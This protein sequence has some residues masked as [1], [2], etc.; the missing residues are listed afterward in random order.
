MRIAYFSPFNPLKSGISDFSEELVP[1]LSKYVEIDLF[2]DGY[3]PSNSFIKENLNIYDMSEFEDEAV[4]SKY[5]EYIYH[6]GNNEKCHE[7]IVSYALRYPGI[8]ELHDI[9]L[10]H[11]LAATTIVGNNV[12]GYKK[13]MEYCHGKKGIEAVRRFLNGETP[14]PWETDSLKYTVCKR[15]ID[16]SKAVIVHSDFAKQMIKGMNN[17][18]IVEKIYLHTPDIEESFE[19]NKIRCREDLKIDKNVIMMASFGFATKPKRIIEIMHA[20]KKLKERGINFLYYIVGQADDE[21]QLEKLKNDLG[22]KDNVLV[23]GFVELE[24]MKKLMGA[25]DICFNLRNPTQGE[26]SAS[27]HR[28]I[29]MGKAVFVSNIG[30]FMEYPDDVVVKVSTKEDEIDDI[31]NKLYNLLCTTESI[32]KY[33]FSAMNFAKQECSL[34]NNAIKYMDF[35]NN[36]HKGTF[37]EKNYLDILT[38]K[39]EELG[40]Y[41]K[42]IIEMIINRI[43]LYDI[44]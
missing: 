26:S 7:K 31:Y 11:M 9:S 33:K 27:L 40:I 14:P 34:Q 36:T 1:E 35:I 21:L 3:K 13:E 41:E 43:G 17:S 32:D 37:L 25:C 29:G 8:L 15:I 44:N 10:H 5:D 6:V 12:E 42:D 19:E 16:N 23:T 38:D 22:L 20:L 24:K 28:V 2:A 30:S 18:K 39:F 4:R